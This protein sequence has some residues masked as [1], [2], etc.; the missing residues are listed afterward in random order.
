MSK[1]LGEPMVLFRTGGRR[2]SDEI[3]WL[4]LSQTLAG[5]AGLRGPVQM[6]GPSPGNRA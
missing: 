3:R 1:G 2:P 5:R 4:R 6:H